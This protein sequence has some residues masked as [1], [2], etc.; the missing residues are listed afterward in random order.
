MAVL[1]EPDIAQP[2][3]GNRLL[4]W[5]T[6]RGSLPVVFDSGGRFMRVTKL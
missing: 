3:E 6:W 2:W 4:I 5:R 1:G